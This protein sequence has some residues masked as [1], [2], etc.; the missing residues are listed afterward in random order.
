MSIEVE[1]GPRAVFRREGVQAPADACGAAYLRSRLAPNIELPLAA[2][3]APGFKRGEEG[4]TSTA[5]SFG[6]GE[7]RK[8]SASL[9]PGT[10]PR[11]G[12]TQANPA[13]GSVYLRSQRA[14]GARGVRKTQPWA[15]MCRFQIRMCRA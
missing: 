12:K 7:R 8:A 13:I 1:P 6:L 5:G 2:K 15:R 9:G 14:R 3:A 4:I 10:L 11:M